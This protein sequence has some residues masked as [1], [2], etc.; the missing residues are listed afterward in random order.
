MMRMPE[1]TDGCFEL[2]KITEKK[3]NDFPVEEIEK[4][5]MKI[6]YR[7]ISVFDRLRYEFEQ[8][9]KEITMK[10]R[11]PRYKEIDSTCV[12]I[13]DGNVHRVYNAAH[14]ESKDGFRETE[15]TLTRPGEELVIS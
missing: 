1:Y 7:E 6:W 14:V 2:G 8:S 9:N 15:L 13:I 5:G 4:M 3:V 10:I 11:I 12:C